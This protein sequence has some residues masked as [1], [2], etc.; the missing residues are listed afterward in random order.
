MFINI[1]ITSQ[2][3]AMSGPG[4]SSADHDPLLGV[5]FQ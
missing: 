1:A 5:A 3:N 2:C 4:S